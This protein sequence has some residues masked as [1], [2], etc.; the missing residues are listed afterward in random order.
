MGSIG[1]GVETL[2]GTSVTDYSVTAGFSFGFG[3]DAGPF[4]SPAPASGWVSNPRPFS[5]LFTDGQHN[6]YRGVDD[7]E[8]TYSDQQ[9][10][11]APD[12]LLSSVTLRHYL[13]NRRRFDRG[14]EIDFDPNPANHFYVRYAIGGYNEHA[15]KDF[16]SFSGLD[17]GFKPGGPAGYLD[18]ADPSG[19]TF[20]APAATVAR[21][22]TDTEEETR[23]QILSWGGSD[24]LAGSA[25]IDYRGAYSAGTDKFPTAYNTNFQDPNTISLSYNN[26][27]TYP[28]L[29]HTTDGTNL[30][31]PNI[32]QLTSVT[33]QPSSSADRE[34]SGAA[35]VTIPFQ[36]LTPDDEVKTGASLRLRN[37]IVENSNGS[38]LPS[39][40]LGLPLSHFIGG[41]PLIFYNGSYDIGPSI[42]EASTAGLLGNEA[43][44][45]NPA[46]LQSD[47]EN[48]Y[49]AYAQYSG[50]HGK[51]SWL[52]GMRV[53]D[54]F[55]V[56]RGFSSVTDASGNT[57]NT[58]AVTKHAYASYFPSVQ[59]RYDL[60]KAMDV[61]AIY[62]TAI[63]RPGFQQI[64]PG[65]TFNL[66]ALTLT[67]GNAGLA[68][69][70][71]D[72]FDV[73]YEYYLQAGSKLSFGG[74]DKELSSYIFQNSTFATIN[75]PLVPA[76]E[77]IN[78]TTYENSGPARIYGIESEYTQ[79]FLFLPAP[80][81]GFG[82]DS[83]FTYNQSSASITRN[84]VS[85]TLQLPQTS[86]WNF[87]V[88]LFYEHYPFTARL[89][90]NYVSKDLYSLGG[91]KQTDVYVQQRFRLDLG[92]E[93]SI[94]HHIQL[95][96]DGHNLTDQTLKYTETASANRPIQREFYGVDVLGGVR[97]TY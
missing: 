28:L 65:Q 38:I 80:W 52:A 22:S 54:T 37:R 51:L 9:A 42:D 74:F 59:L 13:Y 50:S 36:W 55:G 26:Q 29:F 30:L 72:N 75:S 76:N 1:S 86:P 6:D 4:G 46:A 84:G 3:H 35:N 43:A 34:Y 62:S 95:Y 91:S 63:G 60:T 56:Y 14:G 19:Q 97:F 20:L 77:A 92:T 10:A 25:K 7:Y 18:P 48:V 40:D 27:A 64:T 58:P 17:S 12:K 94:N 88:A 2:R 78:I 16:L 31:N 47:T 73:F 89:A 70:Y 24:V 79:Q 71:S 41:P 15:G 57:V 83:N 11:G 85:E 33:N 61:R 96:L 67:T 23:N 49:A 66:A 39:N 87:N 45:Y 82:I 68:P 90:A 53:E 5:V 8:P 32:Y 93:Y 44:P 21:T 81:S 69:I